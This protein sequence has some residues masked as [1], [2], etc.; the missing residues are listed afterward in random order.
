MNRG[1]DDRTVQRMTWL[2]VS[3]KG[4]LIRVC[5]G[6]GR[7]QY[8]EDV[9]DFHSLP[10]L[11]PLLERA[12]GAT[13]TC[14]CVSMIA[15][16]LKE[17]L[18]ATSIPNKLVYHHIRGLCSSHTPIRNPPISSTFTFARII[19]VFGRKNRADKAQAVEINTDESPEDRLANE[20][21]VPP[22]PSTTPNLSKKPS[23]WLKKPEEHANATASPHKILPL[24]VPKHRL[25]PRH[26]LEHHR[27]T[28]AKILLDTA[29]NHKS[30]AESCKVWIR[31]AEQYFAWT[32]SPEVAL[33]FSSL[34]YREA[35]EATILLLKSLDNDASE[36]S[37]SGRRG[38]GYFG[39]G[40]EEADEGVE[41]RSLGGDEGD[42]P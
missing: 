16:E 29:P 30:S 5:W 32:E 17:N 9:K 28:K 36:E 18:F 42:G 8:F 31:E 3:N 14:K 39:G 1:S 41:E 33:S 2:R 23:K 4:V 26:T 37:P 22:A 35:I 40:L 19:M 25:L 20:A 7:H 12:A 10:P 21:Q 6:G 34:E 13:H 27:N 24:H 11:P 38:R 15:C